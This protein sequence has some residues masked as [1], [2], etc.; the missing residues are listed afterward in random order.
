[1]AYSEK[2]GKYWRAR[3]QRPDGSWASASR[4]DNGQRFPTKRTAEDYGDDQES[5]MRRRAWRDPSGALTLGEWDTEWWPQQDLAAAS[6]VKYRRLREGYVLPQWKDWPLTSI[7]P[8]EVKVWESE[9]ERKYSRPTAAAARG[10][11]R[12]MLSD[13]IPR[14]LDHNPAVKKRRRGKVAGRVAHRAPERVTATPLQ[15]LRIAERCA[16]LSGDPGDFV[17]VVMMAYTGMRWAEAIGL[18]RPYLRLNAIRVEWQIQE[19]ASRWLRIPPKDDSYGTLALPPFL[20]GL[21]SVQRQ[22]TTGLHIFPGRGPC[23]CTPDNPRGHHWRG[24]FGLS[25][26]RPAADGIRPA[27]GAAPARPV[28]ADMRRPGGEP[29]AAGWPG[30]PRTHRW[31]TMAGNADVP[32]A[33]WLPVAEGLTPHGLRHSHRTWMEEDDIPEVLAEER[34]RHELP[35]YRHTT[36]G[37]VRRLMQALQARWDESLAERASQCPRS[38]LP[39]LDGLLTAVDRKTISHPSPTTGREAVSVLALRRA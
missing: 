16:L 6:I 5:A 25:R 29:F 18:E 1:M 35:T 22:A 15:V 36:A 13:A 19:S 31:T 37:M 10:M 27:V 3:Y 9:L 30:I 24:Y 34:M 39:I 23:E 7:S 4:D 26:F 28:L 11:L 32:L 33:A 21:L 8:T 12:T 38:P 20:A 17:M 2:R 14:Y